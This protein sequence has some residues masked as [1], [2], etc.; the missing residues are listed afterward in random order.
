MIFQSNS[1]WK[2]T[3]VAILI[4]EKID[5]KS[6]KITRNKGHYVLIKGSIKKEDIII[7][8]YVPNNHHQ[9]IWSKSL[10]L[11]EEI[12]SSTLIVEDLN[13]PLPTLDRTTKQKIIK[14]TEEL[15]Q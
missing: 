13:T 3:A 14:K 11:K 15:T 9:N 7:N 5:F 12:G 2:R 10:E 4:S 8:I 1:N 6:K